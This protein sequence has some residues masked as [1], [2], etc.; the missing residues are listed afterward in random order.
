MQHIFDGVIVVNTETISG[1]VI[2]QSL[3]VVGGSTVRAKHIGKD[4]GALFKNIGGGELK[5]Y[6]ELLEESRSEAIG[7]M[8]A[9]AMARGANAIV[10]V[11]FATSAVTAGAAELFAYGTAVKVE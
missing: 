4:I 11:R 6:T 8:V 9:D 10:D 1:R 2:I 7:R 5:A 3:G